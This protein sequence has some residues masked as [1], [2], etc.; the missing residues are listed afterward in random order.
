MAVQADTI[1]ELLV[2]DNK[3]RQADLDQ[4]LLVNTDNGGGTGPLLVRLGLVSDKD[5]ADAYAKLYDVPLLKDDELPD[6][7]VAN[8]ILP[9]RFL[10]SAHVA[11]IGETD[12]HIC[13]AVSGPGG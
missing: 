12:D 10:K 3:L 2:R 4:A 9:F 5:L 11:P 8:Q 6:T 13:I 1:G 7:P